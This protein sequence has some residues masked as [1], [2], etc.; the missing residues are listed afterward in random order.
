MSS[1]FTGSRGQYRWIVWESRL[2]S[3]LISTVPHIVRGK[4]AAV[5]SFDGGPFVPSGGETE[6]G[7][8]LRAGVAYSPRIARAAE[9][10]RAGFDE[11]YIFPSPRKIDP[12]EV[13]VNYTGFRL[14][15]YAAD[16]ARHGLLERFWEQ[17]EIL[18]PESYLAEGDSLVFATANS[19]LY[20]HA[21]NLKIPG[22]GGRS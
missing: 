19:A 4:Y 11:W 6:R 16:V 17:M 21:I 22:C 3:E 1:I 9:L 15:Y 8:S 7:W 14:R 18:K 20:E 13:F 2:L 5:T 12:L 10:P